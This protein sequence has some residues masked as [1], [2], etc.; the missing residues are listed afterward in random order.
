MSTPLE[1]ARTRLQEAG[2][3]VLLEMG[4]AKTDDQQ[5]ALALMEKGISEVEALISSYP[6]A[7]DEQS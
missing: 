3:N 5:E 2:T 6:K 7:D 4:K 1:I